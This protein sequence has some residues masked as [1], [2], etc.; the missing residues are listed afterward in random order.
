MRGCRRGDSRPG[1]HPRGVRVPLL[2]ESVVGVPRLPPWGPT[3]GQTRCRQRSSSG[4]SPTGRTPLLGR[5]RAASFVFPDAVCRQR[6]SWLH[7]RQ[8]NSSNGRVGRPESLCGAWLGVLALR[9]ARRNLW[10][11][12]RCPAWLLCR[13]DLDPAIRS[14]GTAWHARIFTD[15]IRGRPG[16]GKSAATAWR[17][18][19]LVV[20]SRK[21][22]P[23]PR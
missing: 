15:G 22:M 11:C 21:E 5:C 4:E 13:E 16:R 9:H 18:D 8:N 12:H 17:D 20:G 14:D 10:A 19:S 7:P 6:S 1:R 23:A 2:S 3:I